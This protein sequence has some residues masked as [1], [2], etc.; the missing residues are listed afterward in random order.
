MTPE[1]HE[2][3]A[4]SAHVMTHDGRVLNAGR[5]AIFVLY[6]LKWKWMRVLGVPPL[7]WPVEIGYWIFSRNRPFF[8]GLRSRFF[9]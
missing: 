2:A 6:Q 9:K 8:F 3:C 7:I 5:A 1:L 4:H